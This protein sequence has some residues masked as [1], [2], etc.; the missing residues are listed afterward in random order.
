MYR[1]LITIPTLWVRNQ[2]SQKTKHSEQLIDT[3][4]GE[5]RVLSLDI[6]LLTN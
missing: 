5:E 3:G 1:Y 6:V 2:V 4:V